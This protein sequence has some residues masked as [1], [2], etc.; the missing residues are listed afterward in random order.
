MAVQCVRSESVVGER[1]CRACE[2]G[3]LG[4][5]SG[6]EENE[7]EAWDLSSMWRRLRHVGVGVGEVGGRGIVTG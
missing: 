6:E 3:G 2:K 7:E 5:V 4:L 1:E